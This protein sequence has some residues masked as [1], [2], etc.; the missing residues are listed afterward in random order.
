M[1]LYKTVQPF[2]AFADLLL[3]SVLWFFGAFLG[4]LLTLGSATFAMYEVLNLLL[5]RQKHVPIIER[6]V[7][8][9]LRTLRLSVVLSIWVIGNGVGLFM[10][11]NYVLSNDMIVGII[12]VMVYGYEFSLFMMYWLGFNTLFITPTVSMMLRNVF[13]AMHKNLWLN[14]QLLSP[15][16]IAVLAF[17]YVHPATILITVVLTVQLQLVLLKRHF[18]V[19]LT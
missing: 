4:V 10:L 8:A 6:F 18:N 7:N 13:L 11:W 5:D 2:R 1:N 17:L 15:V 19:Y 3:V 9:Y 12:L 16:F 14:I